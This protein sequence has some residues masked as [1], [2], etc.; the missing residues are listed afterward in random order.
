MKTK[1][2]WKNAREIMLGKSW[3]PN[4]VYTLYHMQIY[5]LGGKVWKEIYQS[6]YNYS[7]WNVRYWVNFVFFF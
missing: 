1:A 4:Y 5:A 2:A 3:L 7:V 6:Y